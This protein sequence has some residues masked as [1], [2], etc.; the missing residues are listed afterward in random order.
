MTAG[1]EGSWSWDGKSLSFLPAFPSRMVS[2]AG[3]GDAFLAGVITGL[4]ADLPLPQAQELGTLVAALSVTSPHTI[5]PEIDRL[6]LLSFSSEFSLTLSDP[7]KQL[8]QN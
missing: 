2:T 8:L 7:V 4:V 6:S 1:K 3:A 5:N